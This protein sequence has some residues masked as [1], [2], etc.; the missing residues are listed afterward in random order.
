MPIAGAFI[1]PHPPIILPKIGR[2]EERKIQKTTDAY[3]EVSRQ[4][5]GLHPETVVI[6]SPHAVMYRD[7]F[8]ISPGKGAK[9]DFAMFGCSDLQVEA[10]YDEAFGAE[11]SHLAQKNDIPAGGD[12]EREPG[13]DHGTMIPLLFMQEA[14]KE[15]GRKESECKIV[16]I[17]LSGLPFSE[18]ERLGRCIA[19]TAEALNRRIVIIASGDLSHRLLDSGP[20]EFAKQGP[21]YDRQ[22]TEIM[23]KGNLEDFSGF[24]EDFC[25]KAGECGHRAFSTMAGALS[26]I[27]VT[28]R[29]L[30]YE[31][32][33]GVG[34]AVASFQ[35]AYT[36]L[37]RQSLQYYIQKNKIM[38]VPERLPEQLVNQKAGVFVSLKESGR[39]RGCIGTIQGVQ[40]NTAK[41]IIENA[42]SAGL[43]DPRFYP[44]REEELKDIICTVDVLAPAQPIQSREELDVKRY[45]VIVTRGRKRGLL[46]PNLE[47]VDTVEEQI[48]IALQ[49]AGIEEDDFFMERFEVVRH[50]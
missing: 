4:L 20:Y 19:Q 11:L 14:L 12:G 1:V 15:A 33:F 49:K 32:P 10:V 44:V 30:S 35:D 29:L 18:H 28:S 48:E 3:R 24:S 26:G 43:Y 42:V 17:G 39:L 16:R 22:V 38:E 40:E 45:G 13:L 9:G 46:L 37:A 6:L 31:G 34:Y 25:E 50:Y 8:H 41:E 5:M 36:A 27:P 2:G 7:Y 21:E 23:S 47:G